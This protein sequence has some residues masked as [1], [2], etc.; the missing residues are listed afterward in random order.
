MQSSFLRYL[1]SFCEPFWV[2]S[3]LIKYLL[4][5]FELYIYQPKSCLVVKLSMKY[6]NKL[7]FM[8]RE[9]RQ[10]KSREL[11]NVFQSALMDICCLL[12]VHRFLCAIDMSESVRLNFAKAFVKYA[13]M[14]SWNLTRL[15]KWLKFIIKFLALLIW[16]E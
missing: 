5:L 9:L 8:S 12:I 14:N 7:V 16:S 4:F 11:N 13:K 3:I 1:V 10:V 15:N 6:G 2:L